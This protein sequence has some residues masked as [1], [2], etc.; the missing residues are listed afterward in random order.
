MG[1]EGMELEQKDFKG[2][3]EPVV[4][5][6]F[7]LDAHFGPFD[8]VIAKR[9]EKALQRVGGLAESLGLVSITHFFLQSVEPGLEPSLSHPLVVLLFPTL[10]PFSAAHEFGSIPDFV[11]QAIDGEHV[12]RMHV[13]A[14][15]AL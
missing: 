2:L 10:W 12:R 1:H 7:V 15:V 4:H 3:V 14:V 11:A 8:V 13:H 9:V 6:L 5:G